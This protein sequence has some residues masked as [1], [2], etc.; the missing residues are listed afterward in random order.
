[1]EMGEQINF[2]TYAQWVWVHGDNDT[3]IHTIILDIDSHQKEAD[4]C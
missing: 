1:M 2:E 3:M 4:I